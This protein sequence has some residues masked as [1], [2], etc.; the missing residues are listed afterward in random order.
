M[1]IRTEPSKTPTK[2]GDSFDRNDDLS[3]IMVHDKYNSLLD[4]FVTNRALNFIRSEC[5]N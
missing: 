4:F 1:G 3:Y 5:E 2:D